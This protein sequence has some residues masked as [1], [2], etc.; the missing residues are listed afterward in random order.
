MQIIK[1]ADY[2]EV[3][4]Y[5]AKEFANQ[6]K[7]KKDSVLGLA[8]GSTPVG[9][10]ERLCAMHKNEGLDFSSVKCF[11]LDEYYPL[12]KEDKNS[13]YYFMQENL[14][15]K[16]NV[17]AE[18]LNIPSGEAKDPEAECRAYEEKIAK[19]GGID[20]QLL[21]IGSNGHIG[22]NEPGDELFSETH[23]TP[24][25]DETIE[26]N[27]RFFNSKEEVPTKALTM[28][29]GSIMKAKRIIIAANGASKKNAVEMLMKGMITTSCPATILLAHPNVTLVWCD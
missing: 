23:L 20:L 3:S 28:G 27:A 2:N 22:F 11:N 6:I 25:T 21:G 4:D 1:C 10:Y 17:K 7:E 16:V 29:I 9:A 15:S 24:L 12:S 5:I 18:N 14:F 26:A 8:T 13:Y 19:A